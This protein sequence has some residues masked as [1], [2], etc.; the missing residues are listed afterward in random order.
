MSVNENIENL[1]SA[2][3][4]QQQL[5]ALGLIGRDVVVEK[6]EFQLGESDVTLGYH[7]DAQDNPMLV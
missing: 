5:S 4:S 6:G 3:Q 1:A 7:L 2:S